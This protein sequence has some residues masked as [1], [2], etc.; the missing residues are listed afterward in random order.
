M[1]YS[2]KGTLK[3]LIPPNKVVLEI[4]EFCCEILIPFNLIQILREKFLGKKVLFYVVPFLRKE[5]Y[6]ELYGFLQK[7]E[8]ELF[9]KLT[10]LSKIGPKTA[11]NILSVFSPEELRSVIFEKKVEEL[12]RIPGIGIRR[13]EKLF[14]DLKNL[15]LKKGKKG[16]VLPPEK[17]L[18]LEEAK[19]CLVSLGFKGKEVESLLF[20]IYEEKDN[21]ETLI[22]KA[23][24]ELVPEVKNL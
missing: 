10:T 12:A 9:L 16:I 18:L 13:A 8:R 6:L 20:K 5:E 23:L 19:S 21:L 2:L 15:F 4:G 14:L 17:E 1:L 11:L 3:E 7:E 24:K 22:K